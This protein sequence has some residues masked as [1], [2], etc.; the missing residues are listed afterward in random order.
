MLFVGN[1]TNMKTRY[2]TVILMISL[3]G[4][5]NTKNIPSNKSTQQQKVQTKELNILQQSGVDFL[6]DGNVPTNWNLSINLDDTVRFSAEDGLALKFAYNQLR[7]NET[8][9]KKIYTVALKSGNVMI[10]VTDKICTVTTIRETYKKEVTVKFNNTTYSGCGKFLADLNLNGK[11]LLEKIGFTPIVV[12]EYNKIPELNINIAEG[13]VSGNDGCNGIR[14]NI[15]VQ[16]K[17]IQFSQLAGTKMACNKKSI[18]KIIAAQMN[19]QLVSY[20]FKDGKLH[21]YL[22]DDSLLIFKKS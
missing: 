8:D 18:G 12:A 22:P 1:F 19:G 21:L 6:A 16:G 13:T 20:Y 11:W 4:C 7:K 10:E 2:F 9:S 3:F 5:N 14:G 15:E 17:R